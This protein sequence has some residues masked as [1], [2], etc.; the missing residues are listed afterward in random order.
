MTFFKI[1]LKITVF[2]R[3]QI[4][5]LSCVSLF[6][7]ACSVTIGEQILRG[8]DANAIAQIEADGDING[9][10]E[11]ESPLG[12]SARLGNL[13]LVK[14]LIK[15]GADPNFRS[16]G[17]SQESILKIEGR[18]LSK[19]RFFIATHTPISKVANLE[20]AKILVQAGANARIGGY[21]QDNPQGKGMA[22]YESPLYNSILNRK[23]ELAKYLL[24]QGASTDLYNPI[25]GENEF[26]IWFGT[27]GI[28]TKE[29]RKFY[30]FLKSKGLKKI[31]SV[32]TKNKI[33][34]QNRPYIHLPTGNET[35]QL[36]IDTDLNSNLVDSEPEQRIFHSSEFIWKDNRQNLYEWILQRRI[37]TQKKK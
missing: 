28:K 14:F 2:H 31:S 36:P 25:N 17:C 23:Y 21:R 11:C 15:K 1:I 9:S 18:I 3:I 27:V 22:I 33:E 7:S 32:V 10:N 34:I 20:I 29:D 5:L 19:D 16:K 8:N 6:L 37:S 4:Y 26:E 30:L 13:S 12:I 24:E 35:K